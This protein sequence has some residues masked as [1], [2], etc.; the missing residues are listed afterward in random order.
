[1]RTALSG[2][3]YLQPPTPVA[4]ANT[5]TTNIENGKTTKNKQI[6]RHDILLGARYNTRK[7]CPHIMGRKKEQPGG[8]SYHKPPNLASK[9]YVTN[10]F[11]TNKKDIGN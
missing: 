10:I 5:A 1:M 9:N 3:G 8:I 2:M 4:T 6:N 11:K 7:S